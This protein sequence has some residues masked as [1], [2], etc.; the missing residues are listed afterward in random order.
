LATLALKVKPL[1]AQELGVNQAKQKIRTLPFGLTSIMFGSKLNVR[2]EVK[3]PGHKVDKFERLYLRKELFSTMPSQD[4]ELP[5][6]E[7]LAIVTMFKSLQHPKT[8]EEKIGAEVLLNK[9]APRMSDHFWAGLGLERATF[10]PAAKMSVPQDIEGF[11]GLADMSLTIGLLSVLATLESPGTPAYE[12]EMTAQILA[13]MVKDMTEESFTDLGLKREDFVISPEKLQAYLD[14][15]QDVAE[16][17]EGAAVETDFSQRPLEDILALLPD[18]QD[19][20]NLTGEGL[21]FST[22][23]NIEVTTGK[24]AG[25][26]FE[27]LLASPSFE[28]ES[29]TDLAGIKEIFGD[30]V[31]N[32]VRKNTWSADAPNEYYYTLIG[33]KDMGYAPAVGEL[34]V[35]A[36]ALL[37]PAIRGDEV[38]KYSSF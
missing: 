32:V 1:V 5:E 31:S 20:Q 10:V 22:L 2:Q 23:L 6:F 30:Q 19:F 37:S 36:T 15:S 8:E 4:Y 35:V 17:P 24:F 27:K 18:N 13:M 11:E 12:K 9:I 16:A 21:V 25:L 14:L 3:R 33:P 28:P 38:E 29:P 7:R 34:K 26:K